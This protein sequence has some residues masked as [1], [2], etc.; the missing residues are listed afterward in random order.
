[1]NLL[2][3][4]KQAGFAKKH[5]WLFT[6]QIMRAMKLTFILLTATFLQLSATGLTQN[7]TISVKDAPVEKVFREIEKQTGIG[8][9]YTRKMLQEADKVSINVKN[10]PVE[11]VLKQCFRGQSFD[12][13]IQNNT[14]IIVRKKERL[15]E[16]NTPILSVVIDVTGLISDEDGNPLVGASIIVKGTEQGATTDSKG[17]FVLKQINEKAI[18]IISF[19][20]FETQQI[21]L[22]GN[23]IINV[24]LKQASNVLNETVVIGYG[25]LSRKDLTG[26]VSSVPSTVFDNP[27]FGDIGYA[28]QG[29][30]SGVNILT[31]DASPGEPVR[32]SIRGMG[33]L[34]GNTSPLIVVD[35]VPMPAEFNLND[36]N[37]ESIKSIDVLKGASSAAIY[38]SRAA[39]GVLLITTKRATKFG[40]PTIMYSFNQGF[41]QLTTDIDVLSAEE[42]KYML[43]EGALNAARFNGLSN[44]SGYVQ[45]QS[46]LAAGYFK[47]G[48]DTKWL[49]EMLQNSTF[50][51]HNLSVTG[52]SVNSNYLVSLGYTNDQGMLRQSGFKRYNLNASLNTDISK[53]IKFGL[54]LKG[55]VSTRNIATETLYGATKGRPDIRAYNDDGSV[56]LNTYLQDGNG[57]R[58]LI[59]SPL[60]NLLENSNVNKSKTANVSAFIQINF[61]PGF[62]FKSR[63][64]YYDYQSNSR[65]YYSSTTT[66]GSGF[67]FIRAGRLYDADNNSLQTEFENSVTYNK[68]IKKHS[69]NAVAATS[70][71]T[72]DKQYGRLW[73]D[74]FPDNTLQTAFYQGANFQDATGYH[75]KAYLVS[76]LARVNYKYK[77]RYLLTASFR[78]DGSSKF[79]KNNAYGNFPSLA[80]AYIISKENFLNKIKWIDQIKLRA[81]AGK[82]GLADVG[83]Y[84][85]RTTYE[86]TNYLNSPAVVP[87]QVGNENL[88]WEST[89]QT[90]FGIDYSLFNSRLRGGIVY[91]T[92]IT[93]GLLYPFA[94]APSTGFDRATVNFAEIRN[95][96]LDI[97]IEVGILKKKNVTWTIGINYNNNKNVVQKLDKDYITTTDGAQTLRTTIIKEGYPIGL[98]YGFE[99]N[100]IYNTT[101]Q[102]QDDMALAFPTGKPFAPDMFLG[103][104]RYKD[105]NG[106]GYVDMTRV[107][108]NPDRTVLGHSLPDFSGGFNTNFQFK[109]WTISAFGTYSYGNDKV[110]SQ[111]LFNFGTNQAQPTNV[112]RIALKRWTPENPDSK[113]PAFRLSRGIP[114]TRFNDFSVH[115]ASFIKIQ[116]VSIGY[117][118]S[119]K[120]LDKLKIV[121]SLNLYVSVNNVHTFTK[122]PGPNPESYSFN[123][124]EAAATDNSTFPLN[125]TYNFGLKVNF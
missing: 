38:G 54:D 98:I 73:F 10:T 113:Y 21:T 103:E 47:D 20:G 91:Y 122:Y 92:K 24:K 59:E 74:D 95:S 108:G 43:F 25:S 119:Q 115:D 63:Y 62:S 69:I 27:T 87:L 77:D 102:L 30:V 2:T 40:K 117:N 107:I 22:S 8:F 64:N 104:I 111:E 37:P 55:N 15:V 26:S 46:Y 124:I 53:K 50:Q 23:K 44:L 97:D 116:Q 35:E 61:L 71:L 100:G 114:F 78:R 123:N 88:K 96:G 6:S 18:L 7:V 82:T 72:E 19:V 39:S 14:I 16:E 86:A 56:Y 57:Q 66:A 84:K 101:K 89:T 79:S 75:Y 83:Y 36:L 118:F 9:L 17:N 125:R 70:F 90:D 4:S 121:N 5:R 105:L 28:I 80:A 31:G 11:E 48:N 29:Q 109:Q 99:T 67:G 112:W 120:L 68:V 33:S 45:Y 76:Y 41:D 51:N 34:I 85:W 110:W 32:I 49:N 1:M 60:A 42:F 106:D 3:C 52:G 81:S 94:L 93:E 13:S 65:Q 58:L 12:F